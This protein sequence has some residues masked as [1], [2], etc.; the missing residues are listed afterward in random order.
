MRSRSV[1]GRSERRPEACRFRNLCLHKLSIG[2]NLSKTTRTFIPC[3]SPMLF[4]KAERIART[5]DGLVCVIL[6]AAAVEA[7][8]NDL[9]EWYRYSADHNSQCES[10]KYLRDPTKGLELGKYNLFRKSFIHC[11]SFSHA[12][13]KIEEDLAMEMIA[14]ETAHASVCKK[15]AELHKILTGK[16]WARGTRLHQDFELMVTIRN[17]AVHMKGSTLVSEIVISEQEQ[18]LKYEGHPNF[19]EHLSRRKIISDKPTVCTWMDLI[20]GAKFCEWV[21]NVTFKTVNEIIDALPDAPIS[22][23]FRKNA[24]FN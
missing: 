14:M 10:L 11:F 16:K 19:I 12:L 1:S 22:N 13:L 6:C 3:H 24:Q 2:V 4:G 5:G 7:F 9:T 15:F 18:S 20:E 17:E 21:L 8:V 23:H